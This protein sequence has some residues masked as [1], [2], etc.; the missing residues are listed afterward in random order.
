MGYGQKYISI[1]FINY[2]LCK[3]VECCQV[4]LQSQKLMIQLNLPYIPNGVEMFCHIYL[5]MNMQIRKRLKLSSSMSMSF[6]YVNKV[7]VHICV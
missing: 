3:F 2:Y 1:E 5:K 7:T 6:L 4:L